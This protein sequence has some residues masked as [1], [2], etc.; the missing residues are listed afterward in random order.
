[1]G[2][3]KRTTAPQTSAQ[4]PEVF[5][6]AER[7]LSARLSKGRF[8]FYQRGRRGYSLSEREKRTRLRDFL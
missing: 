1:M 3:G 8:F 2:I 6:G 7:A 5:E 4:I